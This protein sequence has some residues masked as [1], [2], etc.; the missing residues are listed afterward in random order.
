MLNP[1]PVNGVGVPTAHFHELERIVRGQ[2]GDLRHQCPGRRGVPVLVDEAHGACLCRWT[3]L[4]VRIRPSE[5]TGDEL[6]SA[7]EQVAGD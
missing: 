1:V 2:G 6:T 7:L 3:Q 5:Q 4:G